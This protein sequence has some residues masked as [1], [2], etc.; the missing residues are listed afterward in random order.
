MTPR[1]NEGGIVAEEDY[2]LTFVG[3]QLIRTHGPSQCAGRSCCIH[4]PSL[5][6]MREWP[7]NIRF[8]RGITE[9]ICPHGTGH[10]DPDDATYRRTL[11]REFD[12]GIHGCCGCCTQ[13]VSTAVKEDADGTA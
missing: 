1:A 2:S 5:H 12:S 7:L 10:P 11:A 9:R 3:E 6:H 8:D 4:D 13:P